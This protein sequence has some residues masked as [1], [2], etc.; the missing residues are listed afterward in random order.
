MSLLHDVLKCILAAFRLDPDRCPANIYFQF[1]PVAEVVK[2]AH[3]SGVP[4]SRDKAADA[5]T[6]IKS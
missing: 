2:A 3:N 4:S 5:T 6:T 1:S